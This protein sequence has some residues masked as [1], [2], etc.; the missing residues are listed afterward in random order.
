M[1]QYLCQICVFYVWQI[2]YF[3]YSEYS[4]CANIAVLLGWDVW[5]LLLPYISLLNTKSFSINTTPSGQVSMLRDRKAL[6]PIK[7]AHTMSTGLYISL[8]LLRL[9]I[10]PHFY[11]LLFCW[12]LT[13]CFHQPLSGLKRYDVHY[14]EL[15]FILFV[16]E[17]CILFIGSSVVGY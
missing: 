13:R 11:C 14:T 17:A 1:V 15:W 2:L 16:S 5:S 9:C 4:V 8:L 12:H 7:H 3:L 10:T 6:T